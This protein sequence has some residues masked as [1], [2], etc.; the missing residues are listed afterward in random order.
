MYHLTFNFYVKYVDD[1]SLLSEE[2]LGFPK[3]LELRRLFEEFLLLVIFSIAEME[4]NAFLNLNISQ[5]IKSILFK[6]RRF[7]SVNVH[8]VMQ[9]VMTC[10]HTG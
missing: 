3:I 6:E 4:D 2:S 1:P 8:C 5:A 7:E 9:H 10:W